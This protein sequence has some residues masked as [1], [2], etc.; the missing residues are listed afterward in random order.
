MHFKIRGTFILLYHTRIDG[1][2]LDKIYS[3]TKVHLDMTFNH[4]LSGSVKMS[5]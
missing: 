5:P 1:F 2:F 3:F 4:N